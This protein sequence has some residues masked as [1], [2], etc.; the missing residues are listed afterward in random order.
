MRRRRLAAVGAAA[1]AAFVLLGLLATP[2]SPHDAE[3]ALSQAVQARLPGWLHA[4]L[5]GTSLAFHAPWSVLTSFALAGGLLALRDRRAAL[6]LLV[7]TFS[8]SGLSELAKALY[9]RARPSPELVLGGATSSSTAYPSGHVTW[10]TATLL[11]LVLVLTRRGGWRRRLAIAG[12]GLGAA[13]MALSRIYL[14]RHWLMD[15]LGGVPGAGGEAPAP[16]RSPVR[17]AC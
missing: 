12:A 15:T 2:H 14:G 16:G 11:V 17:E 1:F 4:P 8:A 3:I 13:W 10:A 9:G 6:L 5:E 7:G